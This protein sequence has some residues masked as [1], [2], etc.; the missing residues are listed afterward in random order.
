MVQIKKVY[1]AWVEQNYVRIVDVLKSKNMLN[2]DVL[3]DALL[4]V[5]DNIQHCES[6]ELSELSTLFEQEYSRYDKRAYSAIMQYLHF[7]PLV[8]DL[9]VSGNAEDESE[10]ERPENQAE[11]KRTCSNLRRIAMRLLL[12]EEFEMLFLYETNESITLKSLSLYS[13]I[14]QGTIYSKLQRLKNTLRANYQLA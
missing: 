4:S 1:D 13:G 6:I 10:T 12:S 7:E 3:H 8:L 11:L 2:E 9:I 14:P 5:Y